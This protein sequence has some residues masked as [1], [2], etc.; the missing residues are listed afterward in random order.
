MTHK[1]SGVTHLGYAASYFSKYFDTAGQR[2]SFR[3]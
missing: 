1:Q 2:I 3:V